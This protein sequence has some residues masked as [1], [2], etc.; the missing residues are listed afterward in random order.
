MNTNRKPNV[1]QTALCVS[2]R[3]VSLVLWVLCVI[4]MTGCRSDTE[5]QDSTIDVSRI[6]DNSREVLES[7]GGAAA[8]SFIDS[9][10]AGKKLPPQGR[11]IVYMQKYDIAHGAFRDDALAMRYADSMLQILSENPGE[12]DSGQVFKAY[13]LK[14]NCSY[15]TEHFEEAF[16]YYD[17]ARNLA[18]ASKSP[19][20]EFIFLYRLG[21][22]HFKEQKYSVAVGLFRTAH[23]KMSQCSASS[24]EYDTRHQEILSN[25]G[26][27]YMGAGHPDSSVP[28]FHAALNLIDSRRLLYPRHSK[29]WD[30]AR[31]VVMGNMGEAYYQLRRHDSAEWYFSGSISLSIAC[32]RNVQDRLYNMIK[33]A[34]LFVQTNR[35]AEARSVLASVDSALIS[36]KIKSRAADAL[37]LDLRVAKAYVH[38]YRE[39][40]A[41]ESAIEAQIKYDSLR[42]RKW[43][44]TNK[45]LNNSVDRGLD[46]AQHERQ[47][48]LLEKDMQVRRQQNVILILAT[49]ILLLVTVVIFRSM[50]AYRER[51]ARFKKQ[52]E[53][54]TTSSARTQEQLQR[55]IREDELNFMSLIENTNDVLWSVDRNSGLLAFNR[56]FK[57]MAARGSDL[58][59]AVGQRFPAPDADSVLMAWIEDG[60]R[61]VVANGQFELID[62]VSGGANA[63]AHLQLRFRHILNQSGEVTG[64]SCFLRNIT[65]YVSMIDSLEEKNKQLKDIAWVQSHKL[66]GPLTTIIGILEFL[67]DEDAPSEMKKEMLIGLKDK[68]AEM[69]AIIHEIVSKTE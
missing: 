10:F 2:I 23:E 27:S 33:L 14:A 9:V 37:E 24:E 52:A 62:K 67:N 36:H 11:F 12:F 16:R 43:A 38:Y 5:K 48:I 3:L 21:M 45:I 64:V 54:I 6:I 4:Q 20:Q 53:D 26:L 28:F 59:P 42:E 50:K 58:T 8:D 29:H 47:I 13:L 40:K 39:V 56:A 35:Y 41:L 15:A 17:K 57:E 22:S 18:L 44:F 7:R 32:G 1:I 65:E 19:C 31:S 30:E 49:F 46:N 55:K 61:E 66:R 69:D 68:V 51:S 25:V 63:W 34:E 60:Y